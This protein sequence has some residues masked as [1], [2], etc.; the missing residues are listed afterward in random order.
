MIEHL[1]HVAVALRR[2]AEDLGDQFLIG[3]A[4]EHLAVM[5]VGDA[6]H[7]LAV[8]VIAAAFTP[9]VGRLD[10]RHQHFLAAGPVLLLPD[11]PLDVLQHLETHRQP[12]VYSCA[13][14]TNHAGTEHQAMR[15]DLGFRGIFPERRHEELAGTHGGALLK[16]EL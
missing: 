12:G 1:R 11:N 5:A 2:I 15:D 7:L 8:I 6:Q 16:K 10:G 3:R 9:Q 13:G 14:L 4:I